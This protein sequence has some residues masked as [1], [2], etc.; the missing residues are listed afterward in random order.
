MSAQ[1]Q[2]PTFKLVLVGDGGTGKTT[3]VKR[4]LTGEFE[5]KYMATSGVEVHPMSFYTNFGEIR[6]DVWDTAG[7]EKFGGLRDGYYINGQCGII[8]FDVTSRITYKNVPNWHRDLVRVC[9]NIPIVLC[10]NKVD[11]KERKVKAK[12]ITFH[13]KKNLQYF[14]I[15]AKSNYNFEKPFLWLARKLVGNSQ[16]EFVESPALAP[17]EVSVDADLMAKYQAEMDQAAAMPLP[18]E[19]D[20]DL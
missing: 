8:M 7:Q 13:R 10:G 4:H 3:F 11:V 14:D 2:V 19:D 16:L 18:D 1:Q 5:K 15:S 12:T 6:F 20:A 9:E 17:P